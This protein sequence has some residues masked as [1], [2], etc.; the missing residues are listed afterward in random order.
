L[1][2]IGL[3]GNDSHSQIFVE[4]SQKSS[5]SRSHS[6][7][8]NLKAEN[9]VYKNFDAHLKCSHKQAHE[10]TAIE[11]GT[12]LVNEK[13]QPVKI[14][15]INDFIVSATNIEVHI[16]SGT[17]SGNQTQFAPLS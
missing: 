5:H 4:I 13:N 11:N 7:E 8:S 10:N 15:L 1:Q 17:S 6:K 16:L 9:G 2:Y 3:F 14:S 12:I